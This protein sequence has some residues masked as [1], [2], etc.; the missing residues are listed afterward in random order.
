MVANLPLHIDASRVEQRLAQYVQKFEQENPRSG[1]V[2]R[3][4]YTALPGGTTRAVLV[5][6]PY[7]LTFVGGKGCH[8][9]SADGDE[10]LDFVSEYCAGMFGHSHPDII[11]AIERVSKSGFNLG[12]P[13]QYEGELA[14]RLVERFPSIDAIRM[15]NS[16]TEANTLAIAT[17]L[18]YTGMKKVL[19]FEDGYHGGTLSFHNHNAMILPHQ[20]VYGHYNDIERTKHKIDLDVG[21]ILVEPL[22]GSG[23]M[24][25]GDPEFLRYLR[26]EATRIGAVLIFDEV[27][28]SRLVY[29]GL[30]EHFGVTPDMTTIGKHFG[31]GFSFGAYG[32]R[33]D[34][35]D[36]FNPK[37][38]RYLN[39][40]G[41]W[42][43]NSF[44]MAAGIVATGLLSREALA[45]TSALGDR[46]RDGIAEIAAAKI[47]GILT[48]SGFGSV[49]GLKWHGKEAEKLRELFYFYLLS[50]H[51]Y[52]AHRGF[53]ALNLVHDE[54]HVQRMLHVFESFVDEVFS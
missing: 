16:G 43:N 14:K 9:T 48:A 23:G 40:S 12:G 32:G 42:S 20:F 47:P 11:E 49:V 2:I 54:T 22:Q 38:P 1:E 27:I 30:Q 53:L 36:L 6:D 52:I 51:V 39:Q 13:N 24:I 3:S 35:M 44:S 26:S 41:T 37:S 28:T 4:N 10:Y 21:V 17:A 15:C 25:A 18:A 46:V 8:L 7:P 5:H 33:R 34:I 50:Q 45:R 19:V 29:G 31:G